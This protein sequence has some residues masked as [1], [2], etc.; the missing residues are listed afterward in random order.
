MRTRA[1]GHR[2]I[3]E[4][5]PEDG[6]GGHAQFTAAAGTA[7]ILGIDAGEGC[8]LLAV[9]DALAEGQEPLL[10]GHRR[11]LAVGI[12]T[13][14]AELVFD[15]DHGKIVRRHGVQELLD[16][17]G[18]HFRDVPR[19]RALLVLD[20]AL[21]L[22]HLPPLLAQLV[23]GFAEVFLQFFVAA[24]IGAE[25]VDAV[26]QFAVHH[27][28]ADREGVDAGLHQEDLGLHHVL[29]DVAAHVPVGGPALGLHLLHLALNIGDQ[30]HFVAHN[31]DCLVHE[32]ALV[33]LGGEARCQKKG[34]RED[35]NSTF[36]INKSQIF[37]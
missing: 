18:R 25:L 14:L 29:Q 3:G 31:G 1:Q 5:R 8:E 17:I 35:D 11:R 6:L 24:E 32:A 16:V 23:Q 7:G 26:G 28:V 36:H 9:D 19:D 30:N 37:L 2:G 4:G 34:R 13:D 20:E 12:D 22:E 21:V 33:L 27:I 10:D 15:R